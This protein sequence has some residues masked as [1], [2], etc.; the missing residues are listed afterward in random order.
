MWNIPAT[1]KIYLHSAPTD[2]RKSFD[3]LSGL[4]RSEFQADPLDGSLFLFV[5]R[6]RDRM[7]ILQ[8]DGSGYWLFY[9]RLEAGTFEI[10]ESEDKCVQI[11]AMQLAMILGGVSLQ[12]AKHRKRYRR[13]G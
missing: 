6:R 4:V 8:W 10:I 13:A 3:G 7:K 2:M 12:S 5:N 1:A 9:R 11:D